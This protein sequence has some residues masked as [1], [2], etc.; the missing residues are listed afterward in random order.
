M[1]KISLSIG[2][3]EYKSNGATLL[4]ALE[5]LKQPVKISVKSVLK[6]SEGKRKFEKPLTVPQ[7]KRLFYPLARNILAKSFEYNLK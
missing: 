2:A 4:E 3:D 1:Y 5:T 7:A 6:V